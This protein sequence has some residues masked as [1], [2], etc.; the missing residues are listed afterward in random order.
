LRQL[1]LTL[2]T[3]FDKSD[4]LHSVVCQKK[5]ER[6]QVE[7]LPRNGTLW[8]V[9]HDDGAIHEWARFKS[10][11]DLRDRDEDLVE[12]EYCPKCNEIGRIG[13]S[14]KDPKNKPY[15]YDYL[16]FYGEDRTCSMLIQEHRDKVLKKLGRYIGTP[17]ICPKCGIVGRL[18]RYRQNK[19]KAPDV[20]S[21]V[22][23]HE[24]I[25]GFWGRSKVRKRKRCY[26]KNQS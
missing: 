3:E 26:I 20:Y 5:G 18:S 22:F 10:F 2:Q 15:Q 1:T 7:G 17:E 9:K 25:G 19:I 6:T 11:D 14:R 4:G 23:V 8:R 24:A 13:S 16:V 12:M 21:T